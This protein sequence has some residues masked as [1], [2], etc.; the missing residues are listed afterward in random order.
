MDDP[1][2]LNEYAGQESLPSFI[3]NY[4]DLFRLGILAVD[5]ASLMQAIDAIDRV[6]VDNGSV[7]VAGNGGS[8]AI[9]DHLCCDLTKGTHTEGM[10]SIP[11]Q[12][13]VA[14][15]ALFTALGND[16]GYEY[17]F[18]RQLEM[19]ASG[20][21]VFIAISS[22]GN[23]DNIVKAVTSA[24]NLGMTVVGMSGFSGGK[25]RTQ[26]DISLHVPANNYGV[27]EDAHQ[28]LMHIIAQV[29]LNRREKRISW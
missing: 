10:S 21:D 17:V 11:T 27:V 2:K 26:A 5:E 22:S 25:L 15:A 14:N 23:S 8:A 4:I 3:K 24:K 28:S 6:A 1:R 18:S 20:G 16:F 19:L 29:I 13:L 7:F 12:S 9:S